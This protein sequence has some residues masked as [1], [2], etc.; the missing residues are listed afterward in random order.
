MAL[1]E[2][3]PSLYKN[4]VE[5]PDEI[6]YELITTDDGLGYG[7]AIADIGNSEL[8][9]HHQ[10]REVYVVLEGTLELVMDGNVQVLK[11]G[12][13]ITIP[14]E[15]K[16]KA[17]GLNGKAARIIALSSPAWA[18]EDHHVIKELK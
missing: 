17:R 11:P 2:F 1:K 9:L 13:S 18:F 6:V 12:E 5:N 7:L 16:H 15:T 4:K 14:V 10:T 3:D 8:H